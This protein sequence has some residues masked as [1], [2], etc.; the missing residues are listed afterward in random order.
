M[1]HALCSMPKE[2]LM[3]KNHLKIAIRNLLQQKTYACINIA[4]LAI[5]LTCCLF[6]LLYVRDELSYDRHH[7]N[8]DRIYRVGLDA[9]FSG[10]EIH[11]ALTGAALA[12]GFRA[13]FPEVEAATRL[14]KPRRTLIS[15][16]QQRFYEEGIFWA[17]STVFQVLSFPLLQG[18]ENT[19]LSGPYQIVLTTTAA[20]KY[21]GSRDA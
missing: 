10:N 18:A 6:I 21:F 3:F 13:A 17:D 11:A 4:G 7:R 16:G 12:P 9:A 14:Y 19:A 2:N 15:H 8:A 1:H 20:Q 5:G